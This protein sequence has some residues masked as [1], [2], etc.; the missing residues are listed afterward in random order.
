MADERGLVGGFFGNNS[1]I[2]F[3]IIVFLLIFWGCT[4][5]ACNN[6]CC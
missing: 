2:L 5:P 3:F 4:G 1:T 6:D